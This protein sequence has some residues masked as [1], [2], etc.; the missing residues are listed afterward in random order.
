MENKF[1]AVTDLIFGKQEMSGQF[2]FVFN[3]APQFSL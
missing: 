2:L 3:L 1:K